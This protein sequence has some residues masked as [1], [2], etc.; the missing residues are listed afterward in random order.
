MFVRLFYDLW[1][2]SI[3]G[4]DVE[5]RWL[6]ATL[7]KLADQRRSGIVDIP[8]DALARHA[9][10]SSR[11]VRVSLD[12]LLAP[13]PL[14][15]NDK[16]DGRRLLPLRP[17]QPDRGW[18]IVNWEEFSKQVHAE[19]RRRIV[20]ESLARRRQRLKDEA[21]AAG[22]PEK[23]DVN[24]VKPYGEE[25]RGEE[26]IGK[27]VTGD[28]ALSL[29][30]VEVES[31][32]VGVAAENPA[33]P[34]AAVGPV[35]K[36][37]GKGPKTWQTPAALFDELV[38]LYPNVNVAA[39]LAKAQ[40]KIRVGAVS[41]KTARGMPK[42]L[43]SWMAREQNSSRGLRP[44]SG[45]AA[46]QAP[47]LRNGRYRLASGWFASEDGTTIEKN[48]DTYERRPGGDFQ[49]GRYVHESAEDGAA[50]YVTGASL[51][52]SHYTEGIREKERQILRGHPRFHELFPEAK[53]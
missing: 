22:K 2:S 52:H 30:K 45:P 21:A 4:E 53:T 36:T 11:K 35:F 26:E 39:E 19:D 17:D 5:T 29:G 27:E 15:R 7:L 38:A 3:M 20:R 37:T 33:A 28:G 16:A 49:G 41:T 10:M 6:W 13:D 51:Q 1:E 14:S 34:P 44:P 31:E 46:P 12:R 42:F 40:A 8:I 48:F 24:N 32:A 50:F 43:H 23:T 18:E 47:E 9:G 25:R